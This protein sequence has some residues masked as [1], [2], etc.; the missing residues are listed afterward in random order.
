MRAAA[1]GR[2]DLNLRP[3][4]AATALQDLVEVVPAAAGL[5]TSLALRGTGTGV[6]V[7]TVKQH[8]GDSVFGRFRIAGIM[9]TNSFAQILVRTDVA[10]S[11]GSALQHVTVKHS[12]TIRDSCRGE[13]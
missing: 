4:A 12:F 8:P 10:A 7:V 11:G 2:E 5:V 1:P 13:R 9:A 3:V 6:K